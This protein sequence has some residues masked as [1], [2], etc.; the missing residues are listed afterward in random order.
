MGEN[1][2]LK[3]HTKHR[4]L[5]TLEIQNLSNQRPSFTSGKKHPVLTRIENNTIKQ[6]G[7][8][9]KMTDEKNTSTFASFLH[10]LSEA[11]DPDTPRTI[12]CILDI[13]S[14]NNPKNT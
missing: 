14:Q 2:V 5:W 7:N 3:N 6:I 11:K 8:L 4:E 10:Q 1:P 12:R 9:R 13:R